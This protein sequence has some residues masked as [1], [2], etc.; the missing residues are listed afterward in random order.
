VVVRR[1]DCGLEVE[2]VVEVGEEDM[3]RPLVLLVAARR[4]ER[5][6]G[7]AAAQG[8][9]RAE[10]RAR[11]LPTFKA[12]RVIR[13]QVEHLRSGTQAEAETHDDG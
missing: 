5:Q 9:R 6:P 8:E 3:Q 2:A 1:V 12:V 4:A 11:S 13:V 7:F 10:R